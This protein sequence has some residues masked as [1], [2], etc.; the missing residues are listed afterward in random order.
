[1]SKLSFRARALDAG[2]PMPICM[3]EELPELPDYSVIHRAVPQ[4]PSGM[5]EEEECVSL[6]AA[7]ALVRRADTASILAAR[8]Q[9]QHDRRFDI[10]RAFH[11][12]ESS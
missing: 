3:A 11:D 9:R 5:E 6:G 1:M 10:S 4:M 7:T 2:K 12:V 8:V